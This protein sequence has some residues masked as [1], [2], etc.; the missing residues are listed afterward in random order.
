M[1]PFELT[2]T[3]SV[4]PKFMSG[5]S[6]KKFGADSNGMSGTSLR[7]ATSWFGPSCPAAAVDAKRTTNAMVDFVIV[8]LSI[9]VHNHFAADDTHAAVEN[10]HS[11]RNLHRSR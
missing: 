10:Q 8:Y 5:A 4:S 6:L 7:I 11:I 9:S 3:P 1:F 2:A